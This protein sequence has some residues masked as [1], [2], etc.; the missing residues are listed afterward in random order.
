M[1]SDEELMT[2]ASKGDINAFREIVQR[3][4]TAV[5]RFAFR[6]TG[7]A[8]DAQ[9]IVQTAFLK[10]LESVRHY[11][12]ISLFKTYLFRIVNNTCIDFSRKKRPDR[13]KDFSEIRDGSPSAVDDMIVKQREKT[14]RDAI[15][16]LSLRHRSVIILRYDAGLSV[17]D[18]ANVLKITEKAAE[19]LLA[20]AREALY[21]RLK[22]KID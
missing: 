18:I 9:D 11:R 3:Y 8:A 5:W 7:D 13:L 21:I 14:V 19:R 2:A 22:N 10:I 4:K 16:N 1:L 15:E 17:R 20:H 6:F 12:H